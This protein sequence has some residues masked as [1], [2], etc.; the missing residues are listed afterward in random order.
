MCAEKSPGV[1]CLWEFDAV[2]LPSCVSSPLRW[3]CSSSR[4]RP[5]VG[6]AACLWPGILSTPQ[7]SRRVEDRAMGCNLLIRHLRE[8]RVEVEAMSR[9][10]PDGLACIGRRSRAGIIRSTPSHIRC[11]ESRAGMSK[12]GDFGVF[13]GMTKASSCDVGIGLKRPAN[14]GQVWVDIRE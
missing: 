14:D 1:A 11:M 6:H 9:T 10:I 2:Y 5:K 3:P 7:R 8:E 13:P 12:E 4:C